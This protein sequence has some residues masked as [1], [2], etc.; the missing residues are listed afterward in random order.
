M[1]VLICRGPPVLIAR[2]SA[3]VRRQIPHA[4]QTSPLVRAK[5]IAFIA[6]MWVTK[7]EVRG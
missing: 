5:I 1:A 6:K 2:Q 7:G 3:T 4:A